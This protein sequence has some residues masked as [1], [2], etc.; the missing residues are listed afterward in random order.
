MWGFH[1]QVGVAFFKDHPNAL[2]PFT[3]MDARQLA[4]VEEVV[5]S[6]MQWHQQRAA[7]ANTSTDVCDTAQQTSDKSCCTSSSVVMQM[8]GGCVLYVAGSSASNTR[9][10]TANGCSADAVLGARDVFA[11]LCDCIFSSSRSVLCT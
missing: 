6:C 1:T 9:K 5:T 7:A 4:Y 2:Y 11:A 8:G 3:A 10:R